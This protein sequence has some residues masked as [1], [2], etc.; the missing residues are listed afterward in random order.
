MK[1]FLHIN[2]LEGGW[3][4]F[5]YLSLFAEQIALWSPSAHIL[6]REFVNGRSILNRNTLLDLVNEGLITVQGREQWF[7]KSSRNRKFAEG[8]LRW[9]D[10]FDS[11]LR[12][13][14]KADEHAPTPRVFMAPEGS[15]EKFATEQ[16]ELKTTPFKVARRLVTENRIPRNVQMNIE[17]RGLEHRDDKVKLLMQIF[18]NHEDARIMSE[19]TITCEEEGFPTA[20]YAE[21]VDRKATEWGGS[22][23][24]FTEEKIRS[25]IDLAEQ[26]GRIDTKGKFLNLMLDTRV[27]EER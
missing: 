20:E 2:E 7:D 16:F 19:S 3:P 21:I 1:V 15:G 25:F 14:A 4:S 8:E 18:K 26:I 23:S 11:E 10:S 24:S 22:A 6:E 17:L 9:H 13:I 27:K 5:P 12:R